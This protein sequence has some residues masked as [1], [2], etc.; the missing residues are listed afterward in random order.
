[1]LGLK[2]SFI[3]FVLA[4]FFESTALARSNCP[5]NTV[6]VSN[7]IKKIKICVDRYEYSISNT[8][9]KHQ[10]PKSNINYYQCTNYCAKQKKRL[11]TH[12]EWL[13]SCEG[14]QPKYCNRNQPHPIVRKL[15]SNKP[16]YYNGLNCKHGRN[17]WGACMQDPSL[18]LQKKSLGKNSDYSKC[19]SKY[20]IYNMV[21]NLGEW[22]KDYRVKNG[23][24][25]GRFNGGLY[26]QQRSS[27]SYTTVA[28]K[29]AYKDYSIGCRCALDINS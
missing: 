20:G 24:K 16:W 13:V 25:F 15:V 23:A 5:P 3:T 14:T 8:N 12:E 29:L 18:N 11:L 9:L 4:M 2:W 26:T 21:G 27:C 1:M 6:L 10:K 22:V 28:H 19:V 17:A 7:P